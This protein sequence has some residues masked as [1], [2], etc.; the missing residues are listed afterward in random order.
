MRVGTS[1]ARPR[2]VA[3]PKGAGKSSGICASSSELADQREAVRVQARRGEAENDVARPT[4]LR[5]RSSLALD[6][7]DR[8]AGE[9]EVAALIEPRH[10]GGLAADQGGAGD[11]AALGDAGDE[12]DRVSRLELAGG[13]IVEEEQRLGALDD[14]IVDAHGDE[15]DADRVEDAGVDGDL[16]LG[17][18][19]VGG[20]DQDR[21]AHSPP[22]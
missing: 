17:A 16:Q 11:P 18:D 1:S 14:E 13:E 3:V 2:L 22:P 6:G 15:V 9:V 20:G 4:S 10:L 7:A 12:L 5:G 19:A 8:E 21:V